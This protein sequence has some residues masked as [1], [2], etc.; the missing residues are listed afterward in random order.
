MTY[1]KKIGIA[2]DQLCNAILGGWPDNTL[3]SRAY[4]WHKERVRSWPRR[5]LNALFFWEADHCKASYASELARNHL[6]K[7]MRGY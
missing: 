1:L 7:S 4:L 2:I 3:S 5:L 6:P